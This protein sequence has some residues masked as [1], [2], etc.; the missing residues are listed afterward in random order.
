MKRV[1]LLFTL[2]ASIPAAHSQGKIV[3]FKFI[4][5]INR[6][7]NYCTMR[8]P[9][10]NLISVHRYRGI[11]QAE[12]QFVYADSSVIYITNFRN[13]FPLYDYVIAPGNSLEHK[14]KNQKAKTEMLE[15]PAKRL[16]HDTLVTR[17]KT[18]NGSL[19]KNMQMGEFSV[20]YVNVLE[21]RL[22]YF[23]DVLSTLRTRK[24][25]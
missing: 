20:G 7:L 8:V 2:F 23:E 10:N 1:I 6:S 13:S 18:Q 17:G 4:S 22:K 25:K 15:L 5:H 11:E 16:S 3:Q 9:Q 21:S 19:W 14:I 12:I 24:T